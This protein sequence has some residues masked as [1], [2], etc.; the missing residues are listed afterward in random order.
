MKTSNLV[1]HYVI[2]G[3]LVLAAAGG[4]YMV[5]GNK[6]ERET[7]ATSNSS[8]SAQAPLS[9]PNQMNDI[10]QGSQGIRPG[11]PGGSTPNRG[12]G[13]VSGTII[14]TESSSIEI[15]SSDGTSRIISLAS[16]PT[17][18]ATE[19]KSVDDLQIGESVTVMGT[20]SSS[21]TIEARNI[22]IVP[23]GST[24]PGG[25]PGSI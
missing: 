10:P 25:I 12:G 11:G 4:G 2:T 9:V 7:I 6:Q 23:E 16:S 5:G 20:A 13:F 14:G 18:T 8:P 3:A 15:E 1:Y 17:I 22:Q 24:L 21:G 19:T